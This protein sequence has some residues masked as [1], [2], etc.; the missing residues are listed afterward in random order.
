M[1]RRRRGQP[2]GPVPG[3]PPVTRT[4]VVVEE[5]DPVVRRTIKGKVHENHFRTVDVTTLT[6]TGNGQATLLDGRS[7]RS[8]ATR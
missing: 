4:H 7:S 8:A 1:G 5:R 6:P 2:A 3:A